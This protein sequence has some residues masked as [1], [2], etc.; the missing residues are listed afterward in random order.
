LE[1]VKKAY[2]AA[3]EDLDVDDNGGFTP[4]QKAALYGHAQIVDFLLSKNCRVDCCSKEDRDTPLIDAVENN[5]L[6]VVKLLLKAGVNPHHQNKNGNRAIDSVQETKNSKEL[7]TLLRKAMADYQVGEEDHE[8]PSQE[9]PVVT[10]R[11]RSGGVRPDLLYQALTLDNLLKYSTSGD[12][13]AVGMLL[14]SVLPDNQCAVA[15]AR[16]GHDVVLNLLLATDSPSLEKDPDP[17]KYAE[18]PLL[19]AIGRGH[20][21][22]IRLLL[23]QDNFNPTRRTKDRKTYVEVARERRGPRWQSEVDLL[24][25]RYD[26]YRMMQKRKKEKKSGEAKPT[27]KPQSSLKDTS[28]AV[29]SPRISSS[30]LKSDRN[31]DEGKKRLSSGKEN[32]SKESNRRKRP[33]VE[34]DDDSSQEDFLDEESA[35]HAKQVKKKRTSSMTQKS[36]SRTKENASSGKTEESKGKPGRK[37]KE[38]RRIKNEESDLD[39]SD[40]IMKD[41]SEPSV[42]KQSTPSRQMEAEADEN[43]RKAAEAKAKAEAAAKEEVERAERQRAEEERQAT[44]RESFLSSLP[45]ALRLA[46]ERG[47]DRPLWWHKAE[48]EEKSR[49]GVLRQFNP[50]YV[51]PQRDIDTSTAEDSAFGDELWTA[52]LYAVGIL[53]LPELT[54]SV[55]PEWKTLPFSQEQRLEYFKFDMMGLSHEYR[56]PQMGEEGHEDAVKRSFLTREKCRQLEPLCWIRFD[57]LQKEVKRR[58]RFENV[59]LKT[60]RVKTLGKGK[61]SAAADFWTMFRKTVGEGSVTPSAKGSPRP[62]VNGVLNGSPRVSTAESPVTNGVGGAAHDGDGDGDGDHVMGEGRGHEGVNGIL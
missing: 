25:E 13:E 7:R 36:L 21:K 1:Q 15:A 8:E 56:W 46:M 26:Q 40:T 42:S 33:V 18:T 41:I 38:V 6:D 59:E 4:L 2:A 16:G 52:S 20:L 12:L 50:I 60:C 30:R 17:T 57:D 5:H 24:Q 3:P 53:G 58:E 54:M 10:R 49:V 28:G 31:D 22:I 47:D 62:A 34:D 9:S 51:C 44:E 32:L 29:K 37:P 14:E 27:V 55:F 23:D 11:D 19:A 48:G 43:A 39:G 61:P 35:R 45:L